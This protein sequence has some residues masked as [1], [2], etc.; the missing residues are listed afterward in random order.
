[1]NKE[2]FDARNTHVFMMVLGGYFA[3]MGADRLSWLIENKN[4]FNESATVA[5]CFMFF[6]TLIFGA[7]LQSFFRVRREIRKNKK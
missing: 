5:L 3:W 4:P 1:V 2:L 7:G 6:G